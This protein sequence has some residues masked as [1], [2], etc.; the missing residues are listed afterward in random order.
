MDTVLP[1]KS[2]TDGSE[3]P[4][5]LPTRRHRAPPLQP[6]KMA[7]RQRGKD[8]GNEKALQLPHLFMVTLHPHQA[9]PASEPQLRENVSS[10]APTPFSQEDWMPPMLAAHL[11][12]AEGNTAP[13]TAVWQTCGT[14]SP[15]K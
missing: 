10:S 14:P 6:R 12:N 5:C 2:A 8:A 7:D 9:F 15:R 11:S 1:Y 4:S 13:R 3:T